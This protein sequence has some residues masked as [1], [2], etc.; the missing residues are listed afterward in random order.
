MSPNHVRIR[1]QQ[2]AS[3]HTVDLGAT[4]MDLTRKR[5]ICYAHVGGLSRRYHVVSIM[6]WHPT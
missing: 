4:V 5:S 1:S 3:Q 2:H 6:K